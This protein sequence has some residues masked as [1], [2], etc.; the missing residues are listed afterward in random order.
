MKTK[1]L[2]KVLALT[3]VMSAAIGLGVQSIQASAATIYTSSEK[4]YWMI[5]DGSGDYAVS[6]DNP[7]VTWEAYKGVETVVTPAEGVEDIGITLKGMVYPMQKLLLFHDNYVNEELE[8]DAIVYSFTSLSDPD[9]QISVIATQRDNSC[10]YTLAL[11]DELEVRDGYTYIKGTDQLTMGLPDGSDSYEKTGYTKREAW[12]AN[13][14]GEIAFHIG[15]DGSIY[16]TD[17]LVIGN[18]ANE[19]FLSTSKAN[20]A[21]TEYEARYTSEYVTETLTQLAS[22]ARMEIKWYGV[23]TKTL[24]FHIRG[25][26]GS[27]IGDGGGRGLEYNL[28]VMHSTIIYKKVNTLYVGETYQLSDLLYGGGYTFRNAENSSAPLKLSGWYAK[29]VNLTAGTEDTSTWY[30]ALTQMD[31]TITLNTPGT[32]SMTMSGSFLGYY[33]W[34]DLP[35]EFTF[36]VVNKTPVVYQ[37]FG[38]TVDSLEVKRWTDITLKTLTEEQLQSIPNGYEFIG[39]ETGDSTYAAGSV[40]KVN[41]N[42]T[43]VVFN[44]KLND[45]QK[46]VITV[47]DYA[48]TYYDGDELTLLIATV[49][50]NS[51][52]DIEASVVVSK[53][54]E[55][56]EI[57]DN[58]L[59]LNAGTYTI[60]YTAKDGA[61]NE[62]DSVTKT[63][64]VKEKTAVVYSDGEN[65]ISSETYKPGEITLATFNAEDVKEGYVFAGWKLGEDVYE[66]GASYTLGET[67]VTFV[68]SFDAI[69]YTVTLDYIEEGKADEV[70]TFTIENRT[71]K[72]AEIKGKLPNP[73]NGYGHSWQGLPTILPLENITCVEVVGAIVYTITFEGI[74]GVEPITFTVETKDE[75]VLPVLEEREGYTCAWNKTVSELGLEDVTLTAVYEAIEYT[76]TVVVNGIETQVTYTIENRE[77]KLTDILA[78]K[79]IADNEYYTYVWENALPEELP[80]ENGHVYT[81][82]RQDIENP[83][84]G[85]S[86]SSDVDD[87]STSNSASDSDS[88]EG[89]GDNL[90]SGCFGSIGGLSVSIVLGIGAVCLLKKKRK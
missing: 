59:V 47:A 88:N 55:N 61:G 86:G 8:A 5:T 56:V 67:P 9:R 24:D 45:V 37:A 29:D 52:D 78:M 22:G 16:Y 70:I 20:L 32:Y 76:A 71:E 50:D 73:N 63:V 35:T 39:W 72:L 75:I 3:T 89:S 7:A 11:T 77:D 64:I 69:E 15:A 79:P 82:I 19:N 80:L 54:G 85:N 51:G 66:A 43:K 44:A 14:Q 17:Y 18:V 36:E 58:K 87:N 84:S 57:T 12:G 25:I 28:G 2:L 49:S 83:D 30:N 60:T 27:W 1:N 34:R 62:A 13:Y 65:T 21:G 42:G 81:V 90:S 46:P 33:H 68:A 6:L 40:Y 41:G 31:K 23:K 4:D 53:D 38:E 74:E 48:E 10:W 26:N